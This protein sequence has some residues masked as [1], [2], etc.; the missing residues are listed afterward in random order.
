MEIPVFFSYAHEDEAHKDELEKHLELLRR[1]KLIVGWSDRRIAPGSNW[2]EEINFNIQ[3]ARIIILLV[4][5]DFL[6]SE[7]CYETETIFAL[8]QHEK[9]DAVVVPII[10]R[11]CYWEISAFKHLQLLPKNAK[12]IVDWESLDSAWLSITKAIHKVATSDRVK[13]KLENSTTTTITANSGAE[14]AFETMGLETFIAEEKTSPTEGLSL[15]ELLLYFF[16]Q[17]H[18]FYFSPTRIHKWG[19][20]QKGFERFKELSIT[21]IANELDQ[22]EKK[23]LVRSTLSKNDNAMYKLV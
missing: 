2:D 8:E 12:P 23:K 19:G 10:V 7:Y 13:K 11:P 3:N 6:A 1:Q 9:G 16:R 20:K 5:P 14:V 22:M 21:E 17:Y 18:Q 15:Q 4:S